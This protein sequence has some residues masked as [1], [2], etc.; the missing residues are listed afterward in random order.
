[1]KPE[2]YL[3]AEWIKGSSETIIGVVIH[4]RSTPYGNSILRS[5]GLTFSKSIPLEIVSN[6]SVVTKVGELTHIPPSSPPATYDVNLNRNLT[7]LLRKYWASILISSSAWAILRFGL[8]AAGL[9]SA[10][11]EALLNLL[12]IASLVTNSYLLIT[13]LRS[14]VNGRIAPP[15]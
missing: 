8:Y 6:G 3:S 4:E 1:M 5:I 7:D 12:L 10:S 14:F 13:Q 11:S 9:G 2:S 15:R